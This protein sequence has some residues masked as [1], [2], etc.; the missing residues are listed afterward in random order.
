M[1]TEDQIIIPRNEEPDYVVVSRN[2]D[3][4]SERIE[5]PTEQDHTLGLQTLIG[6]FPGAHGLKY[7]NPATGAFRALLM[8][9]SG[10]KFYPPPD[11]EGWSNKVFIVLLPTPTVQETTTSS[12]SKMK[13]SDQNAKR[14]K[15]MIESDDADSCGD[16]DAEQNGGNAKNRTEN[17]IKRQQGTTSKQKRMMGGSDNND[18]KMEA[19]EDVEL[20]PNKIVDL[21]VLSLPFELTEDELK[22]HFEQFGKVVH[23]EVKTQKGTK[24]NRGFGFIQ[25]AD[26][27]SQQKVLKQKTHFIGG[28]EC[29]VKVP[30]TKNALSSKIFVGQIKEGTTQQELRNL[31][32]EEAQK[33]DPA[34]TVADVYI[35]RPFRS[36]G[37]VTFSSPIVAKEL[38]KKAQF[39]L[40]GVPVY[41]STAHSTRPHQQDGSHNQFSQQFQPANRQQMQHMTPGYG[42]GN[43]HQEVFFSNEWYGY[44]TSGT[45]PRSDFLGTH[46]A[47]TNA[48]VHP[49]RMVGPMFTTGEPYQQQP[50]HPQQNL[51][52]IPNYNMTTS[53]PPTAIAG[54]QMLNQLETLNLNNLGIGHEVVNAIKAIFSVA[55]NAASANTTATT[56]GI[57]QQQIGQRMGRNQAAAY[58]SLSPPPVQMI[59]SGSSPRMFVPSHSQQTTT[60]SRHHHHQQQQQQHEGGRRNNIGGGGGTSNNNNNSGS[61]GQWR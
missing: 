38:L 18:K 57:Q 35:P 46:Q 22:T 13:T 61:N 45:E 32:T 51:H 29:P 9:K 3:D 54:N 16:S 8:D 15:L 20:M 12:K 36:F 31:F 1:S 44:G 25:M 24:L 34:A 30:Y 14:R 56:A 23:C 33:I 52:L 43:G 39:V 47:H 49:S 26:L 17:T 40:D 48:Q 4:D 42:D 55:Q 6:A 2:M 41:V 59:S 50:Q 7:K 58:Q 53:G 21:L 5:L 19:E 60:T 37:F 27:E 28:R 11:A 10:T